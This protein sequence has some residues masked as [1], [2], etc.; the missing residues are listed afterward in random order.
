[1]A[2]TVTWLG[3]E[4]HVYG[5]ST[6]WH[7]VPGLYVFA[8][9]NSAN[10][11]YALYIGKAESLAERLPTH[12]RWLEATQLGATH[13]HAR[14]EQQAGRRATLEKQLIENY[15]PRLNVQHRQ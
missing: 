12:E 1:M 2:S 3:L 14:V 15:Q 10:E 4:F 8:G 13:V 6:N 5:P 11:W 9:V 7:A